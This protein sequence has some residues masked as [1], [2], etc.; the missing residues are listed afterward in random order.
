MTGPGPNLADP[1]GTIAWGGTLPSTR[2]AVLGGLSGL[3]I[4]E[5]A[6]TPLHGSGCLLQQ[7]LPSLMVA[8]PA[9]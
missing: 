7:H 3:G 8:L 6:A 9:P 1:V 4:G 2:R 5:P